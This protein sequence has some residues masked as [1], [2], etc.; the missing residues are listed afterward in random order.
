[1]I[2]FLLT[3]LFTIAV[4]AYQGPEYRIEAIRYGT[5]SQFPVASFVVGAPEDQRLDIAMVFWL[6]RGDD[7]NILFDSGF[8]R[9]SWN[10]Y[11]NITD[12]V[13]PDEAVRL[14]GLDAADVTDIIISHA[15]WDHIGG[16]DLFPNAT[17]WIQKAEFEY[18]VGAAWQEGGRHGGIDPEDMVTLVRRNVEGK[19]RLIDGDDAEILPRIRAYTG[20][21]HTVASQYLLVETDPP[22]VLASDNC[23]L[24]RNLETRSPIPTFEPEDAPA[25]L[26]ALERMISLA[27]APERVI[28]GHD[29]L[30]FERFPGEDRIAVIKY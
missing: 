30:L 28:P 15:H 21:R 7:R 18:Y 8:Y 12:F 6:I 11:F 17:I 25:N 24:Y 23:Y 14:A 4:T 29:P 1:M 27:G 3:L 16:I 13:R 22:Y 19:L 20:G 10:E 9:E 2:S 5:I 26:A